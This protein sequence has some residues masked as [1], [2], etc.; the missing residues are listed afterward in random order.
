MTNDKV[1]SL[2]GNDLPTLVIMAGGL[3]S[4]YGGLKQVESVG[5][6]GEFILD[7]SL[8][9][10]QKAGFKRAVIII[11]PLMK[12]VIEQRFKN[13]PT[14]KM[15]VL[16][17]IQDFD[18]EKFPTRKKPL[19]TGHAVLCAKPYIDGSFAVV[20]G[21]DFYTPEV[22][23]LLFEYL[24][25]ESSSL[26]CFAGYRLG[27]T[28][29]AH[30]PVSRAICQINEN[31]EL[32]SIQEHTQ[33]IKQ[34]NE[35][36]DLKSPDHALAFDTIVSVNAWGFHPNF[37]KIL[38]NEFQVFLNDQANDVS[39]EYYLPYAVAKAISRGPGNIKALPVDAPYYGLTYPQDKENLERF[40]IKKFTN[41]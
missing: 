10:A 3:G 31:D 16:E 23:E 12:G 1:I 39:K 20:N 5:P 25:K 22:F 13:H 21:D 34:G 15:E 38:E 11:N 28:L 35:I 8:Q 30:G 9:F 17:V 14:L 6:H 26:G 36:V 37:W 27:N 2:A 29:S 32:I 4:R 7:Y 24:Q 41:I 18:K 40:L 19:G 33:I